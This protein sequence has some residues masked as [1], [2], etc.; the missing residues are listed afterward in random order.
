M[1]VGRGAAVSI[2]HLQFRIFPGQPEL[3][4]GWQAAAEGV[5]AQGFSLHVVL[6]QDRAMVCQPQLWRQCQQIHQLLPDQVSVQLGNAINR[7]K[8]GCAHPGE[9]LDLVDHS[10][11]CFPGRLLLGSSVIDSVPLATAETLFHR[12]CWQLDGTAAQLYVDRR[13]SPHNRRGLFFDTAN[14]I[15]LLSALSQ[16]SRHSGN[17][18]W[19]TEVNWPLAG[20]P[21]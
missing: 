11:D 13:G 5:L 8:W 20:H 21:G 3:F 1:A 16:V 9:Y 18:L 19:L 15:R 6:P 14:K 10:Y 4:D 12:R 2:R 7:L 17:R